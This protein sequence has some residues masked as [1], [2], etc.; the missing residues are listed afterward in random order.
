MRPL[1]PRVLPHLRPGLRPLVAVVVAQVLAGA[2]VIG[3][4]FALAGVVVAVVRGD[5]P[6]VPVVWLAV[7]TVL[8]AVVAW[9]VEAAAGRAAGRIGRGLRRSVL[10][11]A[12]DRGAE[13]SG[14]THVGELGLLATRGVAAVEPYVTRYLPALVVGVALPLA[15]VAAI[16]T[17]DLWSALIVVLTL[18]LVPVFAV[19]IGSATAER[20]DRQWRL[21]GQLSG[22]FLDV[23]R[24]LPTLVAH[25]RAT[26]QSGRI[27]AITDRY[28]RATGETLRLAFASSAALELIATISVALVAVTIGLRLAFGHV[29][30]GTALV[31][32]LLAPE[33]Y[34]PLRRVGAEFHAAAEGTATLVRIDALLQETPVRAIGGPGRQVPEGGDLQVRGLR[35]A[36]GEDSPVVGGLD[37]TLPARGLTAISGPSGCGKSTLL[38]ALLGEVVPSGGTITLG[39]VEIAADLDAWRGRV[40]SVG[41]R[42]WLVPGTLADN[43]R[44]GRPDASEEEV[45]AAL[46][47]VALDLPPETVLEEDGRGLSAG[48][49]ARVA[50]ARVLVSDRPWVLLDEPT[51]HLD[52]ATEAVLLDTLRELSRTRGVVV[53][54]HREALLETADRVLELAAPTRPPAR[55][56]VSAPLGRVR[57]EPADVTELPTAPPP[58]LRPRLLGRRLLGALL[59]TL[60]SA[61]GVALTAT[62]GWLIVRASE[63]PPVLFLL[64]AVVSV[65]LFGLGR[66]ALR[67]A[68]RL[69][70]HDDALRLLATRRAEVYDLLVPL[71]PGRLGRRRGDLLASVVDDVDAFVDE[72]LRVRLPVQAWIGVTVLATAVAAL[73]LPLAGLVVGIV[74]LA[75]GGAGWLAARWISGRAEAAAVRARGDL[76]E[77]AVALLGSA[78]QLVLWQ[79]DDRALADVDEAGRRLERSVATSASGLGAGRAV[80]ALSGGLGVIAMAV[81]LA[82][83]VAEGTLGGPLAALLLL[84]PLA[85]VD[86]VSPLADAGALSV[87]TR[88][89]RERLAALGT[90]TPAVHEPARPVGI[91]TDSPEVDLRGVAVGWTDEPAVRDL[92]LWLPAGRRVGVV[93]P[94]G[95]GKSTLAALLL[96]FLAPSAGEQWL[97]GRDVRTVSGDEVRRVTGLVDDDPHVF[98]STVAENVRLAR[99]EADDAEVLQALRTA[100]LGDWLAGLPRGLH[101]V[102]GEGGRGVSGGER[103]RLGLARAVLARTPVLVLDE[104]TAHLDTATARAVTDDL[105]AATAGRSLVWITHGRVGLDAMDDVLDLA[106]PLGTGSAAQRSEGLAWRSWS[107]GA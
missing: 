14:R 24:G 15:T 75:G 74:A 106:D 7:V 59:A 34:W 71:V 88:A 23:V 45:R 9:G 99:P 98:A 8:R 77:R 2:L 47:R 66:P 20:A 69:V 97:G 96:R 62:A 81:A 12:L 19:L 10:R 26:V 84:L 13:E 79:A 100:H 76:S 39:G 6:T 56:A 82:P 107:T 46:A 80:A 4:A 78:R 65:R 54:A 73:I 21:L 30:L 22:H 41:Q 38:A 58:R 42:P 83:S 31:V 51:A 67:Y 72:R 33:A 18:P 102:L 49:R 32:L 87:R 36:Y 55:V 57:P 93:G 92:D 89:A 94:S 91:D 61:F 29:E 68:E 43:V 50:L 17:Q 5:D 48:Q 90:L 40:A 105:L 85:L 37:A 1:D 95:S 63:Q 25:R 101:T 44:I 103:A 70:T 35:L 28:R 16:A 27:R 60:A 53:V 104:P 11:S 3:Q 52:A 64:V 86:V